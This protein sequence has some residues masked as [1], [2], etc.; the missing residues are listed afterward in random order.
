[1]PEEGGFLVRRKDQGKPAVGSEMLRR[2]SHKRTEGKLPPVPGNPPA[3]IRIQQRQVEIRRIGNDH[4][5]D[6][7]LF[8][9]GAAG[10][11]QLPGPRAPAEILRRF[12][13]CGGI[14]VNAQDTP[15]PFSAEPL[16]EYQGNHAR[17]GPHIQESPVFRPQGSGGPEQYA[18]RVHLHGRTLVN[19]IELL[20]FEDAHASN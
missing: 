6:S 17:P 7:L 13:R 11:F 9:K 3:G 12:L 18:V 2:K 1:M 10:G 15:L 16:R 20:E 19:D 14:R 4:V 8:R 5:E